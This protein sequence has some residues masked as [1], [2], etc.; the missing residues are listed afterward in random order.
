MKDYIKPDVEFVG[1]EVEEI[2][3]ILDGNQGTTS[4]PFGSGDF[5]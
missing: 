3:S 1:F 2:T 5:E 4:N